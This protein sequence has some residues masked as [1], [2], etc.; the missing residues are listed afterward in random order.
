MSSD[1]TLNTHF[2]NNTMSSG[3]TLINSNFEHKISSNIIMFEARQRNSKYLNGLVNK[4]SKQIKNEEIT[5]Q[6]KKVS[7]I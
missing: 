7:N 6:A 3:S 1:H 5:T 4:I 2:Y